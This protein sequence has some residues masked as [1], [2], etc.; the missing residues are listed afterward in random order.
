MRFV[1]QAIVPDQ[2]IPSSR[3]VTPRFAG[4]IR[5]GVSKWDFPRVI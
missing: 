1:P 4:E 5:L 2:S 3:I